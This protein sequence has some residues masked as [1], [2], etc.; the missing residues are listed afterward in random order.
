MK[1]DE[2]IE[3]LAKYERDLNGFG[4]LIH[5]G[6]S[7]YVFW[8]YDNVMV[9]GL[10]RVGQWEFMFFSRYDTETLKP[11]LSLVC[12]CARALHR[13]VLHPDE[14]PNADDKTLV[15]KE[16]EGLQIFKRRC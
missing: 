8:E 10:C 13:G 7:P 12:A 6:V 9:R 4:S 14:V 5:F 3:L 1:V 2:R 15:L 11:A 16:G